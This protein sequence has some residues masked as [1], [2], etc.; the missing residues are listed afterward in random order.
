MNLA[1]GMLSL[2]ALFLLGCRATDPVTTA[3][4]AHDA[5][6]QRAR[7]LYHQGRLSEAM[8]AAIDIG[9]NNPN[10][11]GL[12]S[13]RAEIMTALNDRRQTD[14]ELRRDDSMTR[15]MLESMEGNLVPD[16]FRMRRQIQG[17]DSTHIRPKSPMDSVLDQTVSLHFD[18][19][20]LREI[21]TYLGQESQLNLI[22]DQTLDTPPVT[23]HAEDITLRELFDYLSRNLNI[24]FNL[25]RNLIWITP[26]AEERPA[27]PMFTRVY[28]IRHGMHSQ[29]LSETGLDPSLLSLIEAIERFVPAPEGSDIMF[30][31]NSHIL[32]VKNSEKNLAI[33]DNL[34]EVLDV[35][36]PQVL[37]EARFISTSVSDLRELGIDWLLQSD[38]DLS[39]RGGRTRTRLNQGATVDF[40]EAINAGEGF[41]GTFTGIL[42]DP[43]FRAVLHA[44]ELKG[45]ARTLSAPK[46]IAVN[47]RPAYIR[48][49]R[50]LA[51][52]SDVRIERESFGTGD[53]REDLLI[54]DPVV[55]TLETGYELSATVSVGANRRDI[56]LRLRP[57]IVELIRFREVTQSVVSTN[58]TDGADDASVALPISGIE[59]PE[60]ARSIIE[61]EVVVQSGD[62]VALGGLMRQR[63]Q[64][65][66][67][68]VPVIG[69]LPII[70]KL[71]S[72]SSVVREQENL[73][74]FVTATLISKRGESLVPMDWDTPDESETRGRF[75]ED[76]APL[77]ESISD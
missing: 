52:V 27:T 69:S 13:L 51:Y 23:I 63:E 42:T 34:V 38:V 16:T 54:R 75:I 35:T 53:S 40:G 6:M 60:L 57:E 50:D 46:V 29:Y 1:L 20:S 43:Q 12:S 55:D 30:D 2:A 49:G 10:A 28:R 22:A 62:T 45:D 7:S 61:S 14:A 48:I 9:H 33:V 36:P 15:T 65:D 19:V 58:E 72:R 3:T 67:R 5:E 73:L 26:G 39:T 71:F 47:N 70:G 31:L 64:D 24:E 74:V 8:I 76:N 17:N 21:I 32:L 59:F 66:R 18:E 11:P 56:N 68:T 41:T 4:R 37:I 44:L 25:G 77:D